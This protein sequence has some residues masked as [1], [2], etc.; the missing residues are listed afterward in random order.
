MQFNELDS[1]RKQFEYYRQLGERSFQQVE[2]ADLFWQYNPESNSIA[3]IVNHLSGN[4]RSRW[5]NFLT[6]DGEKTWRQRDQEFED[7]IHSRAELEQQWAAGWDCLFEALDSLSEENLDTIVYIRNMGHT[8]SEAINRQLAHYAYHIG[9]IVYLARMRKGADWQS[10]SIPKG[11]STSYNQ[12]KFAQPKR[13][14]HFTDAI[15][16]NKDAEQ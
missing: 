14:A 3:I 7:R 10:L 9:Q 6:E 13:P 2:D 4:M 8:I 1:V 12:E 15:I 16:K 11:A 5:T